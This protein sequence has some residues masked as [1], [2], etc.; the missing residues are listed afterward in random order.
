MA[1]ESREK[2]YMIGLADR[3]QVDS[4]LV[5]SPEDF[6]LL[7]QYDDIRAAAHHKIL[8]FESWYDEMTEEQTALVFWVSK[9]QLDTLAAWLSSN[10]ACIGQ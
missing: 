6:R 8:K 5:V 9:L 4:T 2:P 7:E 10:V 3:T 1:G